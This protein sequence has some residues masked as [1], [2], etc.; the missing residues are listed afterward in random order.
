MKTAIVETSPVKNFKVG[1]QKLIDNGLTTLIKLLL[2][3]ALFYIL[4]QVFILLSLGDKYQ[5]LVDALR[6]FEADATQTTQLKDSFVDFVKNAG[7][8][9]VLSWVVIGFL[10]LAYSVATM[11]VYINSVRGKDT[12]VKD[13]VQIGFERIGVSFLFGL[14]V[15]LMVVGYIILA[16]M[17]SALLPFLLLVILPLSFVLLAMLVV[18]II[19]SYQILSDTEKPKV[20]SIF[21]SSKQL[22][23]K[24]GTSLFL[25]IIFGAAISVG[26]SILFELFTNMFAAGPSNN[27]S[28]TTGGNDVAYNSANFVIFGIVGLFLNAG[29][30]E[31]Y[32]QAKLSV[33]PTSSNKPSKKTKAKSKK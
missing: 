14:Y 25:Y 15:S 23:K 31:I 26:V 13:A 1:G 7:P 20:F 4:Y 3:A 28:L 12:T 8:T 11:R 16:T 18:R 5:D 10:S 29:W 9:L 21:E 19:Y 17:V 2:L 27:F 22:V 24:S 30:V 33:A 32:N 6:V